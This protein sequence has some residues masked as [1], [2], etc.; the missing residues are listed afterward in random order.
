MSLPN[1]VL[2]VGAGLAGPAL[3]LALAKQSIKSTILERRPY[4]QDIGGVIFL[5]ANAMRV[6]DKVLGIEG[7]LRRVGYSFDAIEMYTQGNGA[8]GECDKVGGLMINGGEEKVKVQGLSIGRPV[9]HDILLEE[10]ER[11]GE[12]IQV[13]F[14]AKVSRIEETGDGVTAFMEDGSKVTGEFACSHICSWS[15]FSPG[16]AERMGGQRRLGTLMKLCSRRL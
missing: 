12:R 2:I 13:K 8:V 10:C 15:E 14:G 6:M 16:M 9:L 3:A 4:S 7:R 1:H 11:F 5:A